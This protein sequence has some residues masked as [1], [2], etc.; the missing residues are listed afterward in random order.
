MWITPSTGFR[1]APDAGQDRHNARPKTGTSCRVIITQ[2]IRRKE[3]QKR[4]VLFFL[5]QCPW[6]QAWQNRGAHRSANGT[7][8]AWQTVRQQ[9]TG[10]NREKTAEQSNKESASLLAHSR[11]AGGR[12]ET[13]YRLRCGY[14]RT[15]G[16]PK[17]PNFRPGLLT[18]GTQQRWL[19]RR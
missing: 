14:R 5:K 16:V 15:C 7:A 1:P 17:S 3:E 18:V 13:S 9:E 12:G 2:G 19:Q 11:S 10:P 8:R 6:N 4:F